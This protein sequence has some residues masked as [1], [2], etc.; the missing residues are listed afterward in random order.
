MFD[1]FQNSLICIEKSD[2]RI[3]ENIPSD[4]QDG[5]IFL[6][7]VTIPV[8]KGDIIKREIPSG[9]CEKYIVTNSIYYNG[10]SYIPP[11]YEIKIDRL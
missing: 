10:D 11:H 1:E 6:N 2:G 4:V 7:D 9:I 8:E 3:F 5:I